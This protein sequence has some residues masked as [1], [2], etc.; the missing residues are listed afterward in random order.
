MS[1]YKVKNNKTGQIVTFQWN[2]S[3]PPNDK[4]MEEVF[5]QSQKTQTQT[6]QPQKPVK[7]KNKTK[8]S[9]SFSEELPVMTGAI[10]GGLVGGRFGQPTVGAGVGASGMKLADIGIQKMLGLPGGDIPWSDAF[11][12][13]AKVGGREA[14]FEKG[15]RMVLGAGRKL[16]APATQ[17]L[18]P[19]AKRLA[20]LVKEEFQP[21][22]TAAEQTRGWVNDIMQTFVK[23]GLTSGKSWQT[24]VEKRGNI[25]KNLADD[26]VNSFGGVTGREE[27]GTSVVDKYLSN[28]KAISKSFG[29][30]YDKLT[31]Q[32]EKTQKKIVT[33][34]APSQ[35]GILDA[36]GKPLMTK[37]QK[38]VEEN[39]GAKIDLRPLKQFAKSRLKSLEAAGKMDSELSGKKV[40]NDILT[41][42]DFVNYSN[43]KELR[44]TLREMGESFDISGKKGR[45]IGLSQQLEKM[46]DRQI[47]EGLQ[48]FNPEIAN[49][50]RGINA[51]YKASME[52]YDSE[53]IRS[54]IKKGLP[55][56]MGGSNKPE[57][58]AKA[59]MA[60]NNMSQIKAF[61]KMAGGIDSPVVK[62]VKSSFADQL[63]KNATQ[64]TEQG[65]V[66]QGSK[67]INSLNRY[68]D[69]TLDILF[70]PEQKKMLYDV[71]NLAKISQETYGN[72][73]GNILIPMLQ[74]GALTG[75]GLGL[76]YQKF[77]TATVSAVILAMPNVLEKAITN[78]SL[79]NYFTRARQFSPNTPAYSA[80][81]T[82]I[83]ASLL[84]IYEGQ[85]KK[86]EKSK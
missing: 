65:S 13:A 54:L 7:Q 31:P 3:E 9:S 38:E 84:R 74:T 76:A 21:V 62:N 81:M 60:Q 23:K 42:D 44:T 30:L 63:V 77:G 22:L 70:K 58:V 18:I 14:I 71:G 45:V 12:E 33:E 20:G 53:I 16:L 46:T 35:S 19:E 68:G 83:S 51:A 10:L 34:M 32:L 64:A 27:V 69:E 66:L 78:K 5:V 57:L 25:I 47:G 36:S 17:T 82:K 86:E 59:L 50:W 80:L 55:E 24:F 43:A 56:S 85:Q 49:Q 75:V 6:P 72:Q 28:K 41:Q 37:I 67:F 29:E 73:A 4:D 11:T 48:K 1:I 39:I 8:P 79:V 2:G 52:K 15:P 61:V 26:Y 40:L